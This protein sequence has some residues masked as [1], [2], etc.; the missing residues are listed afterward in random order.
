MSVS[1]GLFCLYGTCFIWSLPLPPRALLAILHPPIIDFTSL[2]VSGLLSL[3]TLHTGRSVSGRQSGGDAARSQTAAGEPL[4]VELRY[5]NGG[6]TKPMLCI[7]TF[8]G[9]KIVPSAPH[10][11]ASFY[12][13]GSISVCPDFFSHTFQ[14][15]ARPA[16]G[17]NPAAPQQRVTMRVQLS[18]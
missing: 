8:Q 12:H 10:F 17:I 7:C 11:K 1:G 15:Q 5:F 14:N 2:C 9:F 3:Q 4:V 6:T 13:F 18:H 16:N